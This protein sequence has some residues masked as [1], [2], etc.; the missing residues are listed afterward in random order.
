MLVTEV[1]MSIFI[2]TPNCRSNNRQIFMCSN[3][4]HAVVLSIDESGPSSSSGM[5]SVLEMNLIAVRIFSAF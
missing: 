5:P 3:E 4:S 1:I 2:L